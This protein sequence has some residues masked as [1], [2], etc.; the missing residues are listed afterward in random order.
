MLRVR[1]IA[2]LCVVLALCAGACGGR[3]LTNRQVATGAVGGAAIVGMLVLFSMVHD[4]E[5][6]DGGTCGDP[7][8]PEPWPR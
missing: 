6:R 3:Q 1:P 7:D 4:C 8:E 5:V 2:A